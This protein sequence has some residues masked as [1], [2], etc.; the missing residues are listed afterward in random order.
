MAMNSTTAIIEALTTT[1]KSMT[2]ITTITTS[3][4]N[5]TMTATTTTSVKNMSM[6]MTVSRCLLQNSEATCRLAD[7]IRILAYLLFSVAL[8][9]QIIHLFRHG[10]KYIAGVSYIWIGW[11][12]IALGALM[13]SHP[14]STIS[15]L[16]FIAFVS[17]IAIFLEILLYADGLHRQQKVVLVA[18]TVGLWFVLGLVILSLKSRSE[19]LHVIGTLLLA[20]HMLP[21]VDGHRTTIDAI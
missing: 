7:A 9:P 18:S 3:I 14:F 2:M 19:I 21:Q 13:M 17:S 20:V 10:S 5:S 15:V 6:N 12:V 16:E 1:T 11:R 4:L 8:L